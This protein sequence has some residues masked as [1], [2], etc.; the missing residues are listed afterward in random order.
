MYTPL[1]P[2]RER[3][4]LFTL[5]ALQFT[6]IVDFMIMMP[7]SSQLMAVFSIQPGDFGLLVSSYSIAAGVSSLLASSLGDRFDRRNALLV[8]YIGLLVATLACAYSNSYSVLLVAR[9]IAGFFG[10][11]LSSIV[12]A[13]VGDIFPPQKRGKAMGIV[14]LAFSLA[15]IAGV[16]LGLFIS[17]HFSWQTPF[18]FI[19]Y[20]GILILAIAYKIVPNVRGHL[21]QPHVNFFRSYVE[22]FRISNHW[23]AFATSGLVMFAGFM[24]IPYIAPTMVANTGMSDHELPYVYLCG[25]LATLFTRPFIGR[26]TDKHKHWKVL[27]VT[28][29]LSFIP[30]ILVTQTLHVG[31]VWQLLIATLFFVFVSGRFIPTSALVTASCESRFRG[32]VMAFSSAVQNLGSGFAALI[33]GAIMIKAPSG[34]ILHYELVGYI[35]CAVSLLAIYTA[36]KVKAVS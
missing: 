25:G 16:P 5:M 22:L 13:I 32:R 4:M 17:N 35:A 12:L 7:L 9:I 20:A 31:F 23:W 33:A 8:A 29:L 27:A 14:M 10:G 2:A 36:T 6:M 30:I 34:E 19:S 11:V 28:S 1:T 21:D 3:I 15:A 26:M 18:S 24:V